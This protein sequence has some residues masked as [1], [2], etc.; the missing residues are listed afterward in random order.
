MHC[1]IAAVILGAV[2]LTG[3]H[4]RAS[5]PQ[6]HAKVDA[7][8]RIDGGRV[9]YKG[10]IL[11]LGMPNDSLFTFFG[12]ATDSTVSHN[13][14]GIRYVNYYWDDQGIRAGTFNSTFEYSDPKQIAYIQVDFVDYSVD[15][16]LPSRKGFRDPRGSS[17]MVFEPAGR[18]DSSSVLTIFRNHF[19]YRESMFG[20]GTY[21][22]TIPL[23]NVHELG[24]G[25]MKGRAGYYGLTFSFDTILGQGPEALRGQPKQ[26]YRQVLSYLDSNCKLLPEH[27]DIASDSMKFER[28]VHRLDGIDTL[29]DSTTPGWS[30]I[31]EIKAKLDSLNAAKSGTFKRLR[32]DLERAKKQR[33]DSTRNKK[34]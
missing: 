29:I 26:T 16:P 2:A 33:T 21:S 27:R 18:L 8:W 24:I 15:A 11:P 1:L 9:T 3:C 4:T 32:E 13:R 20:D 34:K 12:P 19:K 31:A 23:G 30:E 10:R 14:K 17:S 5:V 28:Y 7:D 22:L 25:P 6:E